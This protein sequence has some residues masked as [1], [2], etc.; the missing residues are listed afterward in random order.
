[1]ADDIVAGFFSMIIIIA[2][3]L[4]FILWTY[5]EYFWFYSQPS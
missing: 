4:F 5:L 2:F 3:Q 1:M